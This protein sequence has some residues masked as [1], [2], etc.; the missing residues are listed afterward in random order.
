MENKGN[1]AGAIIHWLFTLITLGLVVFTTFT[2]MK[3]NTGEKLGQLENKVNA[4]E[5]KLEKLNN[6]AEKVEETELNP[7]EAAK[8][9]FAAMTEEYKANPSLYETN[10]NSGSEITIEKIEQQL[11]KQPAIKNTLTK[12]DWKITLT[13]GETLVTYTPKNS[14]EKPTLLNLSIDENKKFNVVEKKQ[15]KTTIEKTNEG[16][17]IGTNNTT[18]TTNNTMGNN[19]TNNTMSNSN[20]TQSTNTNTNTNNRTNT[21]NNTNNTNNTSNGG[22]L[23]GGRPIQLN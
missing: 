8:T 12:G 11:L 4:L 19:S 3:S 21:T 13:N 1:K 20:N 6:Q 22:S 7:V 14:Q 17:N 9:A 15:T 10:S 16:N 23:S 5:Q 18:N 2:M